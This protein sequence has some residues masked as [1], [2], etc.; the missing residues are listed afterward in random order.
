MAFKSPGIYYKEVDNT[1]YTNPA[2]E[3]NTTVAIVGFAKKG[4]IGEP[5]EITSYNSFKSIFGEPITGTYAGLGVRSVL[6]AGGT[7]LF[8]RVADET[9]ASKSNVVIRNGVKEVK[10]SLIFNH[11]KTITNSYSNYKNNEVYSGTFSIKDDKGNTKADT[12]KTVYLRAPASGNFAISDIQK[13]L[14]DQLDKDTNAYEEFSINAKPLTYAPR[15]FNIEVGVEGEGSD[16]PQT[17][18]PFVFNPILEDSKNQTEE[19][20][21][22]SVFKALNDINAYNTKLLISNK[23]LEKI[24]EEYYLPIEKN[25]TT[26]LVFNIFDGSKTET[27]ITIEL[28]DDI[29]DIKVGDELKTYIKVSTLVSKIN[30]GLKEYEIGCNYFVKESGDEGTLYLFICD[31][32][33]KQLMPGKIGTNGEI[34]L[35]TVVPTITLDQNSLVLNND[36]GSESVALNDD[37]DYSGLNDK[38]EEEIQALILAN[39]DNDRNTI[40]AKYIN[41]DTTGLTIPGSVNTNEGRFVNAV[42]LKDD[43]VDSYN[44]ND[45]LINKLDIDTTKLVFDDQAPEVV[46]VVVIKPEG[47][48]ATKT[49][50]NTIN[51]TLSVNVTITINETEI[52][53][54]TANNITFTKDNDTTITF[55]N[56]YNKSFVYIKNKQESYEKLT[57]ED[58]QK[59]ILFDFNAN[60]TTTVNDGETTTSYDCFTKKIV[61][62]KLDPNIVFGDP[63]EFNKNTVGIVIKDDINNTNNINNTFTVGRT[64]RVDEWN[65]EEAIESETN[66]YSLNYKFGDVLNINSARSVSS[67]KG[68]KDCYE[69]TTDAKKRLCIEN[70]NTEVNGYIAPT[71]DSGSLLDFLSNNERI[72]TQKEF[73]EK[74][75]R[76]GNE[77]ALITKDGASAVAA[78][79]SDLIVFTAKEFGSGTSTIGIEIYTVK[80]PLD[81][82]E[83]HYIELF[84]DGLRKESWEDVSYDKTAENYFADLINADPDE[85]GSNYVSVI[86]RE[87]KEKENTIIDVP[88]TSKLSSTGII[89]LGK[90]VGEGTP[91]ESV[92]DITIDDYDQYDY[93]LGNDGVP[94]YQEETTK[95]INLFANAMNVETSGLS[96]KDLYSWHILITPDDHQNQDIQDEA[97][98]L[99]EF[100]E[101]A[102]YIVDP[103]RGLSRD[104]VINWHNGKTEERITPLES[105]YACTYW[106]WVKVYN[107]IDS[108]YQYIMPSIIMAAQFCRVDANY[109]PWYAPAGETNGYCSTALDLEVNSKDNRYPNKT[110]RD[111]LYLNLN[112]IN[113]FLKLRNGNILAFGE[114]TCQ[115]KNSTLTKIHTRRMLVALKK[116]LNSVI[117]GFIFQ[118]TMS[119]NISTIRS[120]VITIMERYKSGGGV[121]S[122]NVICDETN[123]TTETLQQ[124]ILN[125]AVSCVP[126]GCIEQVEI[127]LTL[128]KNA[129]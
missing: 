78:D 18:G 100:M 121:A 26:N 95:Y 127:T 38:Q 80:S 71:L 69:I 111:A 13:Q 96:N 42:G 129:E 50:S 89:Y 102:I 23:K 114:K 27:E 39:S 56:D 20:N 75:F 92:K 29:E 106:P 128:N 6:S 16:N 119:E 17:Y 49:V 85:G 5:I 53:A 4:P 47:D 41:N 87:P 64:I 3:I 104:A 37:V 46:K 107:S 59:S 1:E 48:S 61:A 120:N 123:N 70:K 10:G 32:K 76:E 97:I 94:S 19:L 12:T 45:A 66:S 36:A 11:N 81:E 105:N 74:G 91:F 35:L 33:E 40:L 7:V 115:R 73:E 122:Y 54:L 68:L 124:D 14:Q 126:T 34:N 58:Y 57:D 108:K 86:V 72:L 21:F 67:E 52:L 77:F 113:P 9:T 116:D 110:D 93:Y 83:T 44:L 15:L 43:I 22:E 30:S 103:P 117:K 79:K 88:D 51:L 101:D 118:P 2:A 28:V 25:S 31:K 60:E 90:P 84:V 99:V 65:Y 112:R 125:V 55:N 109:A 82:T 63:V 8:V 98:N 62:G 24:K